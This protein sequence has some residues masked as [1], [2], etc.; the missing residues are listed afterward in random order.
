MGCCRKCE[1]DIYLC[2]W[3]RCRVPDNVTFEVDD[4]ESEWLFGSNRFDLIHSR[5]MIGSF[6]DWK[7]M[8]R[9]AYK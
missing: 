6:T 5:Y 9:R 7:T 8:I 3:H 2:A 4:A 1:A